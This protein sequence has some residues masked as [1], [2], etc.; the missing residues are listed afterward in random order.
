MA[1]GMSSERKPDMRITS[2]LLR[3]WCDRNLD[4]LEPRTAADVIRVFP[5]DPRWILDPRVFRRAAELCKGGPRMN[6]RPRDMMQPPLLPQQPGCCW[7]LIVNR[8]AEQC[9]LL[10]RAFVL[11]LQWSINTGHDPKLPEGL[12]EIADQ[13]VRY[14][15]RA[16]EYPR[17]NGDCT[18]PRQ[19]E[20]R[21]GTSASLGL[22]GRSG[23]PSLACGLI[24]AADGRRPDT[25]V[26]STAEWN[27][28]KGFV[29]IDP[30]GLE[31]KLDLAVEFGVR[32]FF[33]PPG[34]VKIA[35]AH[36]ETKDR[37]QLRVHGF[38]KPENNDFMQATRRYMAQA[39]RSPGPGRTFRSTA[40]PLPGPGRDRRTAGVLHLASP[41]PVGRVLPEPI[42][43]R[44]PVDSSGHRGQRQSRTRASH[45][46]RGSAAAL[47]APIHRQQI[48]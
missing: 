31:E 24:L 13:Y 42:P 9:R 29:D 22:D 26:W 21:H 30:Q 40:T 12:T 20:S 1:E 11:P 46:D 6:Q 35:K 15:S 33:V 4:M 39:R 19:R 7:V 44:S 32:T 16:G 37:H 18:S 2:D 28:S 23:W 3:R 25:L 47:P 17:V 41:P 27:G 5:G 43:S 36:L 45:G 48:R 8:L 38:D 10:R 34:Q 14:W